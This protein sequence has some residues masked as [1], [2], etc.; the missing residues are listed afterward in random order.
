MH[1]RSRGPQA[2]S[3]VEFKTLSLDPMKTLQ[4]RGCLRAQERAMR[5]VLVF[6]SLCAAALSRAAKSQN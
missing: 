6:G 5:T 3:Q 1:V 2:G 4:A